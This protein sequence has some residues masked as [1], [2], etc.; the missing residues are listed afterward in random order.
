MSDFSSSSVPD[1]TLYDP[2]GGMRFGP[3]HCFLCGTSI[4][5][6]LDSVPVF[7]DWLMTRYHLHERQI[8]LLDMSIVAYK[9]LRIAC[10]STC[11]SQHVEPLEKQVAA[12]AA[13]GLAGWR[14]L[15]EK[16]LFLWLGKMFYGV[17][18][19][20]LLNELNPLAR[21]QYPLAENAQ[22]LRRFQ[23]FFQTFQALRV[24]IEFDDFVPASVFVL[25]AAPAQDDIAFEY[26]DDL[27]TLVFSIKL[28][29]TVLTTCLVDNGI[30]RQAM[31]RVY[32]D[33]QRPLHP[34]QI[35]EF[36]ARVYYA[37]YL[38][39][40]VPDYY[41]RTVHPGDDHLVYDSVIDDVTG[42]IFN[43]W[44]N[45]A[46]GQSLL[47]MWK[48]WQIPTEEIMRDPQQPLSLLYDAEGQ[49]QELEHYPAE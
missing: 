44:E 31:R 48:R 41:A 32:E 42:D 7:A 8:K 22:M 46:Y 39:N 3:Q 1:L 13:Q 18:V 4:T 24:P 6:H 2:F 36:K 16:T 14:T 28:N 37:A 34:A 29:E 26:D 12:T 17:L 20:E 19:T 43:P 23:A 5:P 10:C 45:S 11:R 40:V 27:T 47:E 25:E 33:A 15:D 21:P 35:A 38:L 30:I 49:P 9:D